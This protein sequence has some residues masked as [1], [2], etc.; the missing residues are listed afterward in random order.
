MFRRK[1]G[2]TW[3]CDKAVAIPLGESNPRNTENI[4]DYLPLK[5]LDFGPG[6]VENELI[7]LEFQFPLRLRDH[8]IR[9]L[10]IQFTFRIDH[11]RFEPDAELEEAFG[12]LRSQ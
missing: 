10:L 8:P 6:K 3:L 4:A 7:A 5:A 1:P 2:G 9:V 11:F 12:R